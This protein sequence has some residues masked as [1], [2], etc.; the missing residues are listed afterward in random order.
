MSREDIRKK[1]KQGQKSGNNFLQSRVS[2]LAKRDELNTGESVRT[3]VRNLYKKNTQSTSNATWDKVVTRANQIYQDTTIMNGRYGVTQN[4]GN[5]LL[6]KVK[7]TQTKPITEVKGGKKVDVAEARYELNKIKKEEQQQERLKNIPEGN[8][9]A[10]AVTVVGNAIQDIAQKPKA[11]YDG[12]DLMDIP[13]TIASTAGSVGTHIVGGVEQVGNA[14]AQ[15]FGYGM[16]TIDKALGKEEKAQAWIKATQQAEQEREDVRKKVFDIFDK[17]SALGETSNQVAEGYGQSLTFGTVGQANKIAGDALVAT[18]GF[19]SGLQEAYT[20]EDVE[21]W[22]ALMKGTGGAIT[23]YLSEN[24][25]DNLGYGGTK[26]SDAIENKITRGIEKGFGKALARVGY[27]A[28]GESLEEVSEVIGTA[29]LNWIINQVT[30]QVGHGAKFDSSVNVE[31]LVENAVIG[32]FSG[33][34]GEGSSTFAQNSAL[35]NQEIARVEKETGKK[36]TTE[37]KQKIKEQTLYNTQTQRENEIIVDNSKISDEMKQNIK[38]ISQKYNLSNADVE[39][40]IKR[41]SETQKQGVTMQNKEVSQQEQQTTLPQGK[42]VQNQTSQEIQKQVKID[43]E[44]FAKQVDDVKKGIFPKEDML[45]LGKTPQVL[46][47]IGLPDLPITMTQKHLDTIMNEN[48]KYKNAN[49]H[50]LGEEII[51]Q[52]PEAINNPL[53][54]VKSSTKDDSVVLTTYLSDKQGRTIIASVKIDGKGLIND[55]IIDTNVM[56][57]AYGRNNYEKWMQENLDNDRVLYDIDRGVIKKITNPRLQLPNISDSVDTVDN[58]ST[59]TNIISQVASNM[60]QEK[61]KINDSDR[62]NI[63]EL[64]TYNMAE[65]KDA[66]KIEMVKPKDIIKNI[67]SIG[68]RD[69]E[70]I[71][72]LI[73]DIKESGIKKPIYISKE[74]GKIVDGTHRLIVASELGLDEV[75]VKYINSSNDIENDSDDWYNILKER[76]DANARERTRIVETNEGNGNERIDNNRSNEIV[77]RVSDSTRNDR[78]YQGIQE[79]DKRPSTETVY[80]TNSTM[81]RGIDENSKESSFLLP[82]KKILNPIEISNLKIEDANTTPKLPERKMTTGNKESSF[83]ENISVKSKFLNVD[84]R[85]ELADNESIKYY[86]G[87]SNIDTLNKAY[88]DLQT[89][90]EKATLEW[91]NK[92][93]TNATAQDTAKGWILLKQYQDAG[94]YESAV[95]V[96]KKMR[97][98]GTSAGQT[99]QAFNILSRLT[100]DGMFYYAQKE[101]SEMYS[102]LVKGKSKKWIEKHQADFDLTPIETQ[103]IMDTMQDVATMEDGYEKKV[104]LAQIQ[105]LITDKIPADAGTSLKTYMRISMLFNPKTQ[106]RNVMGN[107]IM[108]PVNLFSDMFATPIDKAIA[109]RTGLRTTGKLDLKQYGKGFGKGLYES[110]NDFR[111]GINT[112]NIQGNRFE[113]SEGKSFNDKTKL[114]KAL[115]FTD[116]VLNFV[117]DAGDRAFYEG[118]FVNSINNQ[119]VL[120]NATEVTQ[121]MIDI[122][123][124]E[125]LSRTWQ[126]NNAYTNSVLAIRNILNG[127]IDFGGIHTKGLSYGLGD[128]LIPFAKTPANLTKAIVD[129]SPV[130]LVKT[131]AVDARRFTNSL[132]NGQYDVRQQH[133]FVQNLGKGM[134]GSLLYVLGYALAN[135]GIISGEADED[136]D[137]KNFM[138]NSLGISSYSI[139]IGDKSFAYDWAQP[140][141]TSFAIM[142]NYVKYSK[143]NPDASAIDKAINAINIGTEQLLEQ[144]FMESINT[145]LNG[146]GTTLDNLTQAVMELP[147]RLIPTFSKQIA[148]LVD[149]TQ[150]TTFEYGKPVQSAINSVKAKLPGVSKSLPAQVDTLGNEIQKY[151]GDNSIFNVFFNPANMNKGNLSKAGKEIYDLYKETGNT[152]IFPRTAPYYINHKNEKITMDAQQRAEYQ[153]VTGKYVENNLNNLLKDKDYSNLTPDEKSEFIEEIVADSN[154]RAKYEILGIESEAETKKRTKIEN[155]GEKTYYNFNIK[156][157][158][159]QREKDKTNETVKDTDKIS[160]LYNSDY[161]SSTKGKV[162]EYMLN[163]NKDETYINLKTLTGDKVKINDYLGYKTADISAEDD[164]TS[165]IKGKTISGS[166]KKKVVE[167]LNNSKFSGIERLYIYG[168]QYSFSNSQKQAFVNYV[169]NKIKPTN[170]ERKELYKKLKDYQERE[171]GAY[172]LK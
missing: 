59:S 103:F 13:K 123:T 95:Q 162:Y 67:S 135:A 21:A 155:V 56:T 147:S 1:W 3:Q 139:K 137:V 127:K 18:Q 107:A 161:D 133:K 102:E 14:I 7:T 58:V 81:G 30:E 73:D 64:T 143:D 156:L 57:S 97:E 105:K 39:S 23:S 24:M 149:S 88:D 44:N 93:S 35:S 5:A 43:S 75:P 120:N 77:N 4:Q 163:G 91:F 8:L 164:P 25:F 32:F 150:R 165:N 124:Q 62:K 31:E 160:V 101:L 113:V 28:T 79:N 85:N 172:R 98:I 6:D 140:I 128:V 109:K 141:A 90:G 37:E 148:D 152:A 55:L 69:A 92:D 71:N 121:E 47:D 119:L 40:M 22:Q 60:Q 131:L 41:A 9:P 122:A 169:N 72:V 158:E 87:I 146:N 157:D 76:R 19:A 15:G 168:T 26:V 45:T 12:F 114:G 17:N 117:M 100:P 2:E 130:G 54:V 96:A 80:G 116:N 86:N 132:E 66:S 61:L 16:A 144:S 27:K 167:Y 129:Y 118:T 112:R 52:L 38:D 33:G 65:R 106:V 94:D 126:D 51:K 170:T 89:N 78:L 166:K 110:Y 34:F 46:K 36:L 83:L 74:T 111:L 104:K 68:N 29:G 136:K 145:V 159:L 53:D 48:G 108:I 63:Q 42:M 151:G 138:K 82:K 154:S 49:Y 50:G 171:D 142:S 70:T 20:E 153:K 125:A 10:K 99:I 84:F 115:N 11:F 134:A